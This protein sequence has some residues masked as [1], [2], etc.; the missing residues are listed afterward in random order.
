MFLSITTTHQPAT[1]LGFLLHKHPDKIQKFNT[2]CGIAHVFYPES[3][4]DKCTAVLVLDIDTV[5]LVRLYKFPFASLQ[6]YVNDRP[7]TASSF[8][9]SAIAQVY[10]SALNGNCK[11]HPELLDIKMPFEVKISV[12]KLKAPKEM[13]HEIFE[14]LGYNISYIQHP[15]DTQFTAWGMSNYYSLT[16]Q[17]DGITLKEMLSHIFVLLPVFD[18]EKHYW[19]NENEVQVLLK[20]GEGWLNTHQ[21]KEWI[22]R[23]YLKNISAYMKVALNNLQDDIENINILEKETQE[24]T[25]KQKIIQEKR[26]S[27]HQQRLDIALEK[28][29]QTN[30]TKILDLGCGEGKLLKMLL[31]EGQFTQILGCD[32]VFG[33]LQKAKEKLHFDNMS[34]KQ[35]ERITLLQSSLTYKDKRLLGYEAGVLVEVIEHIDEDRLPALEKNIFEYYQLNHVIITTPN[36]EYNKKYEFLLEDDFRHT[37]HRFEWTRPQFKAWAMKIKENFGYD[38]QLFDIGEVDELLGASSQMAVFS[39]NHIKNM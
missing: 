28:L 29:K 34:P 10:S 37:D 1:D 12:I 2:S 11:N 39:K 6:Q 7:Y 9:S 20:K 3:N 15:F 27:L 21:K 18:N 23:R 13:L 38:F 17:H 4:P 24:L 5:S 19:V 33:E 8:M 32:V 25:E 22:T 14:P 31:K 26:Y 36:A 16:L 30:A 35:K